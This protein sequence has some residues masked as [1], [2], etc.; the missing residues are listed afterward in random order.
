MRSGR[1][2][3]KR[4]AVNENTKQEPESMAAIISTE[5]EK[6]YKQEDV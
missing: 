4:R 5:A 6:L 3:T 1:I 2:P